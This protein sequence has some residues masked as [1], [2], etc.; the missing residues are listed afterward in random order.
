[1]GKSNDNVNLKKK[2]LK[3]SFLFPIPYLGSS[4]DNESELSLGGG[5]IGFYC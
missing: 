3:K 5:V 2:E 1:M 4:W